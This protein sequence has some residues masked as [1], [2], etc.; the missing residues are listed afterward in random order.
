MAS[1]KHVFFWSRAVAL[2]CASHLYAQ[3][4]PDSTLTVTAKTVQGLAVAGADI[5]VLGEGGIL[6]SCKTSPEG[7][8]TVS[9]L[10]AGKY[11]LSIVAKGF[12]DLTAE[13]SFSPESP[14]VDAVLN[15][16]RKA[17]SI[18]VE[19][20][21]DVA[22]EQSPAPGASLNKDAV[23]NNVLKPATVSDALPLIPGVIRLPNGDLILS[24]RAEHRSTLLV[25]D[26]N[27]TDP[28][29]GNFGQTVPI[30]SVETLDVLTSPFL[31][32]YGGFSTSVVNV[33]TR[34][35]G[36]KWNFELNDPLPE[37]RI[38]SWQLVG[39][40]TATPRINFNGPLV[41]QK[42]YF[43]ESLQYEMKN[44]AVLTLPFPHNQQRREGI[45]SFSELDYNINASNV[46]T[47]T[48]HSA[49]QHVRFA[50]LDY[51]NPEPVSP[52]TASGAY[53]MTA[54]ERSSLAHGLLLE[55]TL[56]YNHFSGKVWPQAGT[57][58]TLQPTG[59][60]G[61][62]FNQQARTAF[63]AEWRE[64]ISFT[65]NLLGVHNIRFGSGLSGT[66][67]RGQITYLPVDI[68]DT[69]G[70][71]LE[72]I[73]YTQA[74]LIHHDDVV[75]SFYGQD[76]WVIT[77]KLSIEG[78]IRADQQRISQTF[79]A[80]PRGSIAWSPFGRT[81]IRAGAGAFYDRVPLNVYGF[82]GYPVQTIAQFNPNGS[83][84]AGPDSYLNLTA[85]AALALFPDL[86]GPGNPAPRAFAPYSL[87]WNIQLEETISSK[88]RFRANFLQS[89]S[90]GLLTLYPQNIG[91]QHAFILSG[92]GE[93]FLRQFD[94]TAAWRPKDD[95]QFYL[96]YVHSRSV[97]NI[98]EFSYYL[99]NFPLAVILPDHYTTLPG[100][101]PNRILAWGTLSLP[102]K[103][104]I[105]PK[106]EYRTG[107]P[108]SHLDSHQTY[109]GDPYGFRY[110]KYF[111]LDTR[112]SKD[113]KI[114]DKYSVRFSV[115]GA[116]LTNHFNPFSVH[117]NTGDPA[118]GT[119]F[120]QYRRRYS[121]DFD[122]LF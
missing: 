81:V 46:L 9:E 17:D 116:N 22:M 95:S 64:D 72:T 99:A 37:F 83:I 47:V 42:L 107:L 118:F 110:P 108:F 12:D 122:F 56:A 98:N 104:R 49:N 71:L 70:E 61:T 101:V 10:K 27:S 21:P 87:N 28:S 94:V 24:G 57:G 102:S 109:A 41:K 51:F 19:A 103:L 38:R 76:H 54:T 69:A 88:L 40:K 100:D 75:F 80:G 26:A 105:M 59:N 4:T 6:H 3:N 84:L 120:G 36:E 16:T 53:Q 48:L 85:R 119:F 5:S 121:L 111:S 97:G 91:G 82:S 112:V 7:A 89:S 67:I 55:S 115:L 39:L 73:R 31:A 14:R 86:Y 58:M 33:A 35:P 79:R 45:N 74:G 30:D 77:P 60:S 43:S 68:R 20:S 63:R 90:E 78:G 15:V 62:Y 8:C 92:T 11:S 93:S 23:K 114:N 52:N 25:N 113:F 2:L 18:T 13:I 34:K 96:S 32:Q 117:A 29:T 50:N 66:A 44:A 106:A 65:R 1:K